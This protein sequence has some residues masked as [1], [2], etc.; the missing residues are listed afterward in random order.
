MEAFLS[1]P[2]FVL[3][4]LLTPGLKPIIEAQLVC[5]PESALQATQAAASKAKRRKKDDVVGECLTVQS[6]AELLPH[7]PLNKVCVQWHL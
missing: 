2:M 7:S 3:F 5:Q 4:T 6:C 1:L